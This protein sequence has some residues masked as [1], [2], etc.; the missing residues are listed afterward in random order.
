MHSNPCGSCWSDLYLYLHLCRLKCPGLSD[1]WFQSVLH[2][3][4]I[5]SHI[6]LWVHG[7]RPSALSST[8]LDQSRKSQIPAFHKLAFAR[9][10]GNW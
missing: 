3:E 6:E 1:L 8:I 2:F 7:S 10:L 9:G 4:T 5:L